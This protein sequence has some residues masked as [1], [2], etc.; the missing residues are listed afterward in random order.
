MSSLPIPVP[1]TL[2]IVS[3]S[4][5]ACCFGDDISPPDQHRLSVCDAFGFAQSAR[6]VWNPFRDVARHIT[7]DPADPSSATKD[8][9]A[10]TPPNCTCATADRLVQPASLQLEG[11][12][13]NGRGAIGLTAWIAW[14]NAKNPRRHAG[15]YQAP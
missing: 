9:S 10:R 4:L 1:S 13:V 6:P 3:S 2:A 11:G 5:R 15:A 12:H 14:Q 8:E 7:T